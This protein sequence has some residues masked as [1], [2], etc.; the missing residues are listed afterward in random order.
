MSVDL[1]SHEGWWTGFMVEVKVGVEDNASWLLS[2]LLIAQNVE[3]TLE[4]IMRGG[5]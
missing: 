5:H 3:E 4:F 1:C 2:E